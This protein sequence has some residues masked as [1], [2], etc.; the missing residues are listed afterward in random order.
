MRYKMCKD[1]VFIGTD[2]V[3][4]VI[5]LVTVPMVELFIAPSATEVVTL[6]RNAGQLNVVA[7]N[8]DITTFSYVFQDAAF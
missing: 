6:P 1:N 3:V 4:K 5:L 8:S 2:V 7:S